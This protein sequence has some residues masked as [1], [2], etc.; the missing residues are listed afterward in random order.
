MGKSQGV[1]QEASVDCREVISFNSVSWL[2]HNS[3][4]TQ[5]MF[6]QCYMGYTAFSVQAQQIKVFYIFLVGVRF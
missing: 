6:R 3:F 4:H 5:R 1:V 2:Y